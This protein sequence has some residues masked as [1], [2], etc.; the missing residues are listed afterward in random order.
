MK[1]GGKALGVTIGAEAAIALEVI[2]ET[3]G[4]TQ[5]EVIEKAL[6]AFQ[7]GESS[8]ASSG[9][10]DAQAAMVKAEKALGNSLRLFHTI[11]ALEERVALIE[12]QQPRRSNA[13]ERQAQVVQANRQSMQAR[14]AVHVA[15]HGWDGVDWEALHR[16]EVKTLGSVAF[17]RFEFFKDFVS[18]YRE[19]IERIAAEMTPP[20]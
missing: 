2:M 18:R 11:K 20:E 9:T 16:H 6:L 19:Q 8:S 17:E 1:K 7:G 15:K 14:V 3:H 4:L 5:R 10:G 12:R 13:Q